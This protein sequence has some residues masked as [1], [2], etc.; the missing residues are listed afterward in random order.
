MRMIQRILRCLPLRSVQV[1]LCIGLCLLSVHVLAQ[2]PQPPTAPETQPKT[3]PKTEP[4]AVVQADVASDS[5]QVPSPIL[6]RTQRVSDVYHGI[7]VSDPYRWLERGKSRE[8]QQWGKRNQDRTLSVL[9]QI[10]A[11]TNMIQELKKLYNNRSSTSPRSYGS[12]FFF[13]RRDGLKNQ[14]ILY[15]RDGQYNAPERVL[16]DP[17]TLSKDGTVSIQEISPSPSGQFLA[18]ALSAKGSDWSYVRVLNVDSGQ[19]LSDRISQ[20]RW[21]TMTWDRHGLGFFYVKY[22]PR[23]TVPPQDANYYRRVFFHR[24][25]TSVQEDRLIF[26]EGRKKETWISPAASSD[27]QILFI[28]TSVDWSRNDLYFR[29]VDSQGPFLPLAV[30]LQGQFSADVDGQHMYIWTTW[31]ASRGRILLTSLQQPESRRWKVLIPE[32]K[33]VILSFHLVPRGILVHYLE[34][35]TSRLA[36]FDRKG[37]FLRD[38]PLPAKGTVSDLQ[39]RH[40]RTALFFQFTSWI[41]PSVGYRYDLESQQRI[42]IEQIQV[43]IDL[44]LYQTEQVFYPSKDGTRVSMFLVYRRGLQRN[45]NN[46]TELYGYGGFEV[47]LRPN[48]LP[49]VIPWL[50]RGGVFA[51]ANLRGGGEYGAA[52]HHA[53]RRDKKQNVFDDFVAAAE[54]LIKNQYTRPARLA[55]RGGSN[56]G[57]LV[58]AT[59]TQRPDLFG[60]VICQVPLTDMIRFPVST[61]ARLWIPEYGDP[62]KAKEFAWLWGYSPYHRL[63]A[64]TQYPHTLVMT[65]DHDDRV[66]PF[67]AR[68]FAARLQANI[69]SDR[70]VLLRI[71]SK[72]GHGA[73]TPLSKRL[74]EIADRFS[75]LLWALGMDIHR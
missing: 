20:T 10:P 56:G 65:A 48:F 9:K 68:K 75:F 35:V 3:Q 42:Q 55:I 37:K 64:K 1:G 62:Q 71:E 40:D 2:T 39:T 29:K 60:A 16:L 44:S 22:P 15:V 30:G 14:P 31:Q 54:W 45:G 23:G 11:R 7:K 28:S 27:Q 32:S 52:W 63:K 25:G 47:A 41:Y 24:L 67:H 18:Y 26:G 38:I 19:H 36:L 17:N 70:H 21:P 61:V 4:K 74:E 12:R 13:F 66:D 5:V 6:A 69:T 53:G 59:M 49:A 58:A 72:A 33:G 34:D 43:P 57:L 46:P 50:D 51:L 73:G 8:V